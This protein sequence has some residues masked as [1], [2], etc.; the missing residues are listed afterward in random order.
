MYRTQNKDMG[1]GGPACKGR[2]LV[3]EDDAFIALDLQDVLSEAGYDVLGPVATV[4]EAMRLL[5]ED[6]PDMALLDYNLGEETSIPVA[7][8]LEELSVPFMFLS[9]QV[10]S[11]MLGKTATQPQVMSKPFVPGHL[12]S[13]LGQL[14]N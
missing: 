7:H 6:A 1:S 3:V 12:V 5:S 8:K 2:I 13:T 11:V 4:S 14:A 9:G 10:S